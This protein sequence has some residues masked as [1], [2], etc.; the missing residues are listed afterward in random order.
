MNFKK[1]EKPI[2]FI[3]SLLSAQYSLAGK[4]PQVIPEKRQP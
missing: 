2:L 1:I 4:P 3:D